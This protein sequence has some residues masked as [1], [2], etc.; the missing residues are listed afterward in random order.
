MLDMDLAISVYNSGAANAERD[1]RRG[2]IDELIAEFE[3]RVGDI[4]GGL[5][6]ATTDLQDVSGVVAAHATNGGSRVE[7]VAS[8]AGRSEEHT[9]EL[10]SLM[11]ISY[12]VLCMKK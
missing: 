3:G 2:R 12:A 8:A 1:R 7:S 11:R 6:S 10:Q 4:I 5:T 9:S